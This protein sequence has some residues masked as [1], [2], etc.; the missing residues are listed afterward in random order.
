MS[1]ELAKRIT[2]EDVQNA[3]PSKKKYITEEAIEIVNRSLN[4]PEFQGEELLKTAA[5]YEN[6]LKRNKASITEYL[7]AIRFCAYLTTEDENYTE[8]YKK[9]FSDRDFVK[10]RMNE[11][12]E[13]GK[14]KELTSA[15]SRYRK[16][17]LVVEILT[18]SQVPLDMMFLGDRYK[19]VG[20]LAQEM[21]TAKHSKDR[22]SAAK[23]L[24][25]ATKNENQKIELE[26]GPSSTAVSM[27][28]S[29]EDQLAILAANQKKMLEAG[30]DLREVQ[31]TG[32]SLNT[33]E[34]E[35]EDADQE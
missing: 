11:P 26:I 12:T 28:Q 30:F 18:L 19:A 5:T 24:L 23:E 20:V 10:A 27:Q 29:L 6:V 7:N 35:F 25:A 31:K 33:L 2:L 1:T 32:V 34:G 22:I 8:A 15:A 4:E 17:K 16:S 21:Y 13:S 14:Y 3:L 9:V